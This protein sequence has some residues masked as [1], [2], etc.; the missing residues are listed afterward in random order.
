VYL[1]LVPM[2]AYG[3]LVSESPVT[4]VSSAL[5]F[6][7]DVP[8]LAVTTRGPSTATEAGLSADLASNT[9]APPPSARALALIGRPGNPMP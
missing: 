4:T 2:N 9:P 7:S 1:I 3:N 8:E 6:L 5:K